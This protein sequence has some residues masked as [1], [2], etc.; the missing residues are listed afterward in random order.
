MFANDDEEF[1]PTTDEQI[2]EQAGLQIVPEEA[3]G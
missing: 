3:E 1:I 2:D